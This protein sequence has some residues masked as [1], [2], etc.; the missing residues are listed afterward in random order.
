M[1][2]QFWFLSKRTIL[3]YQCDTDDNWKWFK[4]VIFI[5]H[6]SA[7]NWPRKRKGA[8][9][10]QKYTKFKVQTKFL[11]IKY[12]NCQI[13][14]YDQSHVIFLTSHNS[15]QQFPVQQIDEFIHVMQCKANASQN[16]A[17]IYGSFYKFWI[18]R[19]TG[20]TK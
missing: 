14:S 1:N 13:T 7:W 9:K 4:F 15:Q 18:I 20:T 10:I 3:T 8:Y 17:K 11:K 12:K 5:E 19:F 2:W 16:S 6:L